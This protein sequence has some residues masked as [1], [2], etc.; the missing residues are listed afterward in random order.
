MPQPGKIGM[1]AAH[2]K[3]RFNFSAFR[4][5]AYPPKYALLPALLLLLF[6]SGCE[7][8]IAPPDDV[9]P[10]TL[11]GS[12][13][14]RGDWPSPDSVLDLRFVALRF[15]P[16][17][18]SDFLQLNRMEI[19]S[20]LSY[21]VTSD[22]FT[23]TGIEPGLFPYSGVARQITSNIFSWAPIG[24]Y[25]DNSGVIELAEAEV[26]DIVIDVDF[27]AIPPFPRVEIK[28]R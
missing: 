4:P 5:S 8:G 23:I 28:G 18:T 9:T 20:S 26:L 13:N 24:L 27:G 11:H 3:K 22:T 1:F 16:V 15:V 25:G 6:T 7:S 17:D 19:S 14:Y 2:Y 12:I 21:G 10:A